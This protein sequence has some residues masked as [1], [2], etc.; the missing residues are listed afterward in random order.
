MA[1]VSAPPATASPATHSPATFSVVIPCKNEAMH[2]DAVLDRLLAVMRG[3]GEPFE[4]LVVDDGSSDRLLDHVRARRAASPEV[5]AV[6]LSR[7]FG[8]E[9]ALTAGL[10]H[11]A[12]AAVILIDADLQHPPEAI[13]G[14]VALWRQGYEVVYGVRATREADPWLRRL[15]TRLFYRL[16]SGVAQTAVPP[17]A[18]DFRLLDAR[19]VAALRA[20]PE[21]VRFMKGLYTWIGFRQIAVSFEVDRRTGGAS[22]FSLWRLWNFAIDGITGLSS[23]P[24]HVWSYVGAIIALLAIAYGAE[25]VF[26]TVVLGKSV[27]GYPSLMVAILFLGGVQLLSLGVIGE[28]LSRMFLEVK[29]RPLYLVRERLGATPQPGPRDDL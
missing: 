6:A 23:F 8:K 22:R 18:G 27:P 24:L 13:P 16:M 3:L 20:L 12:G 15:A 4:I 19:A 28:Y 17:D 2:I 7:N 14:F 9:V 1:A 21:R 11:A 26:Q 25:V 5:K 29:S 10:D